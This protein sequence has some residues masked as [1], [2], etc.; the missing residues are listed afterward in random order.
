MS[1]LLNKFRIKSRLF[2]M[3]M[4]PLIAVFYY[5]STNVYE[6]F[7]IKQNME[8]IESASKVATLISS[9]VHETQKERGM[10]AGFLGSKG[11]KV[12]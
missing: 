9:L 12:C 10:T 1:K 3:M 8:K 6:N 11:E 7:T 2:I 5:A 4:I